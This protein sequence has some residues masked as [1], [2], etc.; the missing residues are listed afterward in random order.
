MSEL[1]AHLEEYLRLRRALGFKLEYPGHALP[2]FLA[3]LE[4][5]GATKITTELAIAW[6]GL[7]KDALPVH[8]AHRLG[9]VRGFARYLA[10]IDLE[11]EVPPT[12]VWSATTQ[13]RTPFAFSED[14]LTNLLARAR[15]LLPAVRGAACEALFGLL[16]STG[17]RVGEALGL[18]SDDLDL[19]EGVITI[20]EAKFDRSRIIPLHETAAEALA[21]YA[22]ARDGNVAKRPSRRFFLTSGG[23]PLRYQAALNA[24]IE[25]TAALGLR[26]GPVLPRIH[27]LRHH[28]AISSLLEWHRAGLRPENRMAV[29][30]TYLGHVHPAGTYW[31]LSATPELMELVAARL[32]ECGAR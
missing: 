5:T 10:A 28:F 13:R 1:S 18:E 8:R 17:M 31:Y 7:A 15:E 23:C 6:A 21:T 12:G 16:V 29:L 20:R 14:D 2:Q 9:A 25:V 24:F 11:T 22:R 27:D 30:S 4:A 3:Y 26:D 19:A 32:V